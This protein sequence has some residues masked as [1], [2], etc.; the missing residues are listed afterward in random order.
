[1]YRGSRYWTHLNADQKTIFEDEVKSWYNT[2][3]CSELC[4]FFYIAEK[5]Q[6]TLNKIEGCIRKGNLMYN[7]LGIKTATDSDQSV[8]R[9]RGH[10]KYKT[11]YV[12]APNSG[13]WIA[14]YISLKQQEQ[15]GMCLTYGLDDVLYKKREGII[16]HCL[17][18]KD[19][20]FS[21]HDEVCDGIAVI[22]QWFHAVRNKSISKKLNCD[23][24]RLSIMSMIM[25][26]YNLIH[27]CDMNCLQLSEEFWSNQKAISRMRDM[28]VIVYALRNDEKAKDEF[29]Y[30]IKN[31]LRKSSEDYQSFLRQYENQLPHM[32]S[33]EAKTYLEYNQKKVRTKKQSKKKKT[34]SGEKV[35][36]SSL[37]PRRNISAYE[38][39]YGTEQILVNGAANAINRVTAKKNY[40][41]QMGIPSNLLN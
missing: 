24:I 17:H 9:T 37:A 19:S 2:W 11:E 16:Y 13:M 22:D 31:I 35:S 25:K 27:D 21:Q 38:D 30:E 14:K 33:P 18:G 15:R 40:L 39:E 20:A 7:H 12:E 23:G 26:M 4:R 36:D 6:W 28:G 5:R 8:V 3:N 41:N 1:M 32:F 34:K 10:E 29:C